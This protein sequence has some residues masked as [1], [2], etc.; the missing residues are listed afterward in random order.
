M[1]KGEQV[2]AIT[3][4]ACHQLTGEGMPPTF[5]ALKGSPIVTG[6]VDAHIARVMNGK[7]GTAMQIFKDQLSDEDLAA[8]ITYERNSWGNKQG[9]GSMV[10]PGDIAAARAKGP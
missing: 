7:S 4:S 3:C 8:V 6:P 10:Q 9:N 5:P 1:Q 2:F